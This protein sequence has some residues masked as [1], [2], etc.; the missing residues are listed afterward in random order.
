MK[1][2]PHDLDV[3]ITLTGLRRA[4]ESL[5]LHYQ[6]SC[7]EWVEKA[8]T[9]EE[10]SERVQAFLNVLRRVKE[11]LINRRGRCCLSGPKEWVVLSQHPLRQTGPR[12]FSHRCL[13]R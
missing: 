12:S 13:H 8:A 7:V 9:P 6:G 3:V 11:E 1:E 5:S 4:F 2:L 10:R